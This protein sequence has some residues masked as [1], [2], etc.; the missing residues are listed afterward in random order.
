[1]FEGGNN[2]LP[3]NYF[4]QYMAQNKMPNMS[5]IGATAPPSGYTQGYAG[6]AP[7]MTSP[8]AN[9]LRAPQTPA[10]VGEPYY[11]AAKYNAAG[12]EIGGAGTAKYNRRKGLEQALPQGPAYNAAG[13][14]IA[15]DAVRSNNYAID[16]RRVAEGGEDFGVT[17]FGQLTDAQRKVVRDY[18][19]TARTPEQ[20]ATAKADQVRRT[21]ET[22]VNGQPPAP[23]PTAP[24][25][26]P[27]VE[28]FAVAPQQAPVQAITNR[29]GNA[30]AGALRSAAADSSRS[31]I[32]AQNQ[33]A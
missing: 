27:K 22:L 20:L 10:P 2:L 14:P 9:A 26:A 17:D 19:K 29:G 24:A 21:E 25:P 33:G 28:Q 18:R 4:N 8:T 11:G 23:A 5:T 13:R 7:A 30:R 32:A 3:P 16:Q 15:S 1:M 31:R 12:K 6:N